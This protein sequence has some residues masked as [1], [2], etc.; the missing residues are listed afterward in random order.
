MNTSVRAAIVTI[1]LAALVVTVAT[2]GALWNFML[3]LPWQVDCVLA[4]AAA[5]AYAYAFEREYPR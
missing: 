5:F 4:M 1:R 2:V 3:W